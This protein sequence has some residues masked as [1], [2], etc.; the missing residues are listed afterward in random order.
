MILPLIIHGAIYILIGVFAGLMAGLFGIG[1]GLIVV[2]GL[3]FVFQ[4]TQI[5]PDNLIMYVAAGTS[6]A[7]MIITSQASVKAH[8][9]LGTILWPVFNKLWPSLVIGTLLG[10]I[11]ASWIPTHWLKILFAFFLLFVALKML[12]DKQI[13]RP[14]HFPK[15]WINRLVNFLIGINSGLLGVG[16]GI[17]I[18][19]YLAYCGIDIRKIPAVSNLCALS[20]AVVGTLAFMVT[21]YYETT[22]ITYMTGYI[23]WPAVL[24][25]GIPS[26]LLAP[27]GARLSYQLPLHQLKYGFIVILILTALKMLF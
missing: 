25:I 23:F 17:L 9:T 22:S 27:V 14:E 21:G 6:L 3:V 18:V 24:L 20:I 16:G 15:H 5:I 8:H 7:A 1:G 2:P 11:I 12:T 26:S 4:Q 19:P 10:S 13:V